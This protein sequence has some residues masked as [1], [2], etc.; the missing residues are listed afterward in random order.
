MIIPTKAAK[1]STSVEEEGPYDLP[2]NKERIDSDYDLLPARKEGI[3]RL[4]QPSRT[5]DS[6]D[7]GRAWGPKW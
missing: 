1:K 4:L 2:K 5:L 7:F 6:I 3:H